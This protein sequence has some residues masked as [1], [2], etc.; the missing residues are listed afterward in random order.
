MQQAILAAGAL[1]G[2][3]AGILTLG[4]RIVDLVNGDEGAAKKAEITAV[5]LRDRNMT[6]EGYCRRYLDGAERERC[7]AGTGLDDAGN[8][9]L[10][11]VETD[12]YGKPC[13]RLEWTIREDGTRLERFSDQ[14][15]VDGIP[16]PSSRGWEI[17]V[18]NPGRQ[19][20]FQVSFDL[21]DESGHQSTG[22]SEPFTV[23]DPG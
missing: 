4:E 10:V 8:L 13:C 18:P 11:A 7:L 14:V 1:A 6:R 19:G 22:E 15:A 23:V 16:S 3:V 12:G 21:Y 20:E 9:F 5:T 17:W 2:A